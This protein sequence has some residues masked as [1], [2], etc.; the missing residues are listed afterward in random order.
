MSKPNLARAGTCHHEVSLR[1]QEASRGSRHPYTMEINRQHDYNLTGFVTHLELFCLD[2]VLYHSQ[3]Y[4]SRKGR[5]ER[6]HGQCVISTLR[7]HA[8]VVY[9]QAHRFKPC[10][11]K[12]VYSARER[13]G[14]LALVKMDFARQTCLCLAKMAWCECP[15]ITTWEVWLNEE[16]ISLVICHLMCC[17][18][19]KYTLSLIMIR[20][21]EGGHLYSLMKFV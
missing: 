20:S 5:E 15:L 17:Q 9:E 12:E 6:S 8:C 2:L 18:M 7:T 11:A 19:A 13:N 14:A 10:Q 1:L 4:H 3:I 21:Q 16:L